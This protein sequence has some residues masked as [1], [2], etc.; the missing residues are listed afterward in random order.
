MGQ[1]LVKED[2]KGK[3][4]SLMIGSTLANPAKEAQEVG[5]AQHFTVGSPHRLDELVHPD[6]GV[7]RARL[8]QVKTPWLSSH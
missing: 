1:I 4:S 8:Q 5:V 3:R 7:C 6:G 2:S